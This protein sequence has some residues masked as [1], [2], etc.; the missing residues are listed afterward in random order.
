T[1]LSDIVLQRNVA[2]QWLW[3]SDPGGV[4]S[5]RGAYDLLTFREDQEADATIDLIWQKQVPLKVSMV[6]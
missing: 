1:L 5:V 3:Q 6:A 2:D 4:Y